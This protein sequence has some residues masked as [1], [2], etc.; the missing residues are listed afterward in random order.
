MTWIVCS[1]FTGGVFV[2]VVFLALLTAAK[3]PET[4]P[5]LPDEAET[6]RMQRRLASA[7]AGRRT[8]VTEARADEQSEGL[9]QVEF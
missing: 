4:R 7:P 6:G 8:L 9:P 1:V 3:D 2:G 5:P